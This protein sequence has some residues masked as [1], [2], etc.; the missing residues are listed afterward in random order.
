[1]KISS[2]LKSSITSIIG[3]Q[4]ECSI[5]FWHIIMIIFIV[6]N[7]TGNICFVKEI[8]GNYIKIK[9]DDLWNLG[10][11]LFFSHL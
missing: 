5:V 1:M 11:H 10:A 4:I 3:G 2:K 8:A 7:T 9:N 6:F